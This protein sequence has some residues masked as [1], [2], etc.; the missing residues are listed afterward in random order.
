MRSLLLIAIFVGGSL[1]LAGVLTVWASGEP[2]EATP[3]SASPEVACENYYASYAP[4]MV[5]VCVRALKA[6][7]SSSPR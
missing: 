5:P 6:Q 4:H 3:K 1:P 2:I 7:P